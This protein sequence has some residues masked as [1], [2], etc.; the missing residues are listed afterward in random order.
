MWSGYIWLMAHGN[1]LSGSVIGRE[2][3]EEAV[4]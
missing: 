2:L 3:R 1:E 4:N